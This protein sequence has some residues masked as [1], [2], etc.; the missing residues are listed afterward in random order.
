MEGFLKGESFYLYKGVIYGGGGSGNN[1]REGSGGGYGGGGGGGGSGPREGFWK[2]PRKI[3][4]I[5]RG[6]NPFGAF[7]AR[8]NISGGNKG[9]SRSLARLK[10]TMRYKIRGGLPTT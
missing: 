3:L 6:G 8:G 2:E 5:E 4:P 10:K 9:T 7:N 1:N